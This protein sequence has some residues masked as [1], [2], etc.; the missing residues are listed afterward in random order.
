MIDIVSK[1]SARKERDM[2]KMSHKLHDPAFSS[3]MTFAAT[4]LDAYLVKVC[5]RVR[6]FLSKI[7]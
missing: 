2:G 5:Y 4:V 7:Q 3:L 1:L 6:N